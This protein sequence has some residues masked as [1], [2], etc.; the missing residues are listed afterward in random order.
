MATKFA[1]FAHAERSVRQRNSAQLHPLVFDAIVGLALWLVLAAWLF[2]GGP[3]YSRIVLVVVSGLA[4]TAI[5]IPYVLW[6]IS[7]K[8]GATRVPGEEEPFHDWRTGSSKL[9][10]LGL[11]VGKRSFR[12]FFLLPPSLS[13]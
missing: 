13:A 8:H 3:D 1:S 4:L 6:R 7:W 10:R 2:F 12:Y 9:G 11:R 5:G